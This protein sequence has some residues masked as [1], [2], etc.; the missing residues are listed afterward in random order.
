[1]WKRPEE[2]ATN[3]LTVSLL[4]LSLSNFSFF[5]TMEHQIPCII[6]GQL[7]KSVCGVHFLIDFLHYFTFVIYFKSIYV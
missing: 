5:Q 4:S 6:G 2:T 3:S 1:M 7:P